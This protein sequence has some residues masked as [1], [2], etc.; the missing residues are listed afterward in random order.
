MQG[1]AVGGKGLRDLPQPL[2]RDGFKA[3]R[4]GFYVH[5]W[6]EGINVGNFMQAAKTGA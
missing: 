2:K 6:G 5:H 4:E 3:F 1:A